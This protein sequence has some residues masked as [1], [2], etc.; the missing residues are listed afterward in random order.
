MQWNIIYRELDDE[1]RIETPRKNSIYSGNLN[2]N[3]TFYQI[4]E[5][6]SISFY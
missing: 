3:F 1:E 4:L 6:S 5:Y 2:D